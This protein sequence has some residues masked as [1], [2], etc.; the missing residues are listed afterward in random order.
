MNSEYNYLKK[1]RLINRS[2]ES[3]TDRAST[4]LAIKEFLHK[5]DN[6]YDILCL[7]QA[8]S[9]LTTSSDI[10][11]VLTSL[12][13]DKVDSILTAVLMK[14]FI[15]DKEGY[16]LNYNP[17]NRPRRQ[18][19]EGILV[20]NGAI[21]A[22][23]RK[24]FE[25]SGN[26]IGG[27]IG[28]ARMPEDTFTELDEQADWL[29]IERLLINRLKA[30]KKVKGKI[31]ALFLDVD[32][33][34]TTGRVFFGESGELS[35]EFSI[36]DGMGLELLRDEGV[37]VYVITSEDSKIVTNRMKKLKIE[38]YYP[39]IKDK[40]AKVEEL[41]THNNIKRSE[42]AYMGDDINDLSNLLS[43]GW[44]FCPS[45]AV[46]EV[47]YLADIILHAEGG[48]DAIREAVGFVIKFNSR[49]E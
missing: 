28:I 6:N 16:P 9:P 36:I 49:G 4:E 44:S 13:N 34:F 1:V 31:K 14:R 39:N 20:E 33:V 10:N 30:N 19:F 45:N 41:L 8:T 46:N 22:T 43:V 48:K 24:Q 18:D 7:L 15:W 37:D 21:Y 42:I 35:K 32:G 40:Y 38:N 12:I 5:I 27:K 17:N 47:K 23:T 3:A 11:N 26:R 2:S 25:Q 29:I